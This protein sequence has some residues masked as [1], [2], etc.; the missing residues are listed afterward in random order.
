MTTAEFLGQVD[1]FEGL[2]ADQLAPLAEQLRR[3]RYERG[4]V[5]FHQDDPGD[6]MHIIV[7]GRV[8]IS[9][10][11]DDGREKDIALLKSGECFGEMALLDGSNRSANATAVDNLETLVLLREDYLEFLGHHPQIAAQITSIL[12]NRLRSANEMLGDMSFLD[13]PTRVAKHLLALAE[14]TSS[15]MADPGA[16]ETIDIPI[17]QEEL[18]RLVGASR[19]TV[20]R[21]LNSYRRMGLLTTSHRRISITDFKALRRM[22]A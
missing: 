6:R 18:A 8:R 17:A 16:A 4:E 14:A 10:D 13:V 7:E 19:E 21:A 12:T 11:S 22:A 3:R 2:S 1:I 20:S 5:V 15:G 9:L